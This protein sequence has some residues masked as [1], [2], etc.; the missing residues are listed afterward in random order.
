MLE[1]QTMKLN[2]SESLEIRMNRA[3]A[4]GELETIAELLDLK[5]FVD[6]KDC[7]GRSALHHAARSP[8]DTNEIVSALLASGADADL[9]DNDGDSPFDCAVEAEK[10][11]AVELMRK[12]RGSSSLHHAAGTGD[13][14]AMA[15][16]LDSGVD[17]EIR[18]NKGRT[19]LMYAVCARNQN[20]VRFLLSADANANADSNF[21]LSSLHIAA[22]MGETEILELLLDHG[23]DIDLKGYSGSSPLFYA[24]NGNHPATVELLIARGA[25]VLLTS[26]YGISPLHDAATV[27][28]TE[29]AALLIEAGATIDALNDRMRSPLHLAAKTGN[30]E[31]VDLLL[32][33]Y[34]NVN[35]SRE[36]DGELP[37]SNL[38]Q[39]LTAVIDKNKAGNE[40]IKAVIENPDNR[41]WCCTIN[42]RK[43]RDDDCPEIIGSNYRGA[44]LL[45]VG[46]AVDEKSFM[47][48]IKRFLYGNRIVSFEILEC[49]ESPVSSL[50]EDVEQS[51]RE[52]ENAAGDSLEFECGDDSAVY[53]YVPKIL[54][55]GRVRQVQPN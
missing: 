44:V 27:S 51:Y 16:L 18:D 19:P 15:A 20:S 40:R 1:I 29:I 35:C 55:Y 22:G 8:R 36:P 11:E 2:A 3:L 42:V 47:E 14:E 13:I 53:L 4:N 48:L 23:G 6:A 54:R 28:G 25:D 12:S 38:L 30:G 21:N 50:R 9:R 31:M 7:N 24:I 10:V 26:D 41:R 43:F 45:C 32:E 17:T 5:T 39:S 49:R 37:N 33:K 34:A 52:L 46:S